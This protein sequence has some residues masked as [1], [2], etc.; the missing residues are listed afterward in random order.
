M[1]GP[2][3]KH[4]WGWGGH[5]R[6][7]MVPIAV[8][9]RGV[10][11]CH[12]DLPRGAGTAQG[13]PCPASSA[14]PCPHP[15]PPQACCPRVP[16][17][18]QLSPC[19]HVPT[20]PSC[21]H[22]PCGSQP[23]LGHRSVSARA[24][25]PAVLSPSCAEAHRSACASRAAL[26]VSPAP[27][28]YIHAPLQIFSIR[29][30]APGECKC[31]RRARAAG[32]AAAQRDPAALGGRCSCPVLVTLL[33]TRCHI[34]IHAWGPVTVTCGVLYTR[35]APQGGHR[36]C[37]P[38]TSTEPKSPPAPCQNPS[39]EVTSRLGRLSCLH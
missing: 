6:G 3:Q 22:H 30:R 16:T 21:L 12:Q 2:W 24:G 23:T 29:A 31:L 34:L 38:H 15:C 8:S 26:A 10:R 9:H 17:P 27:R 14:S 5:V 20:P 35:V 28:V 37:H 7:V 32:P 1:V 19:P 33:R 39:Q 18:P 11:G 4:R 13:C 25:G 36:P